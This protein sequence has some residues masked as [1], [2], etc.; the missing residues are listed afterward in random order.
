MPVNHVSEYPQLLTTVLAGQKIV[1]LCG[2]GA[3]MSLGS[4]SL[5]WVNWILAGKQYLTLE[6]QDELDHRIGTWTTDELVDAATFLLNQLKA[7]DFYHTFMN[8]T[9]GALY[10]VYKENCE[11]N[12]G[13]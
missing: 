11:I 10:P 12:G 2:A 1:Y 9:L 6:E 5:S 3:S 13:W 7:S 8:R 4:H